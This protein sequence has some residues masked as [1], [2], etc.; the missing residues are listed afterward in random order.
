MADI[1]RKMGMNRS[2]NRRLSPEIS[3]PRRSIT[4]LGPE[5]EEQRALQDKRVPVPGLAEAEQHPFEAVLG[6]YES[7]IVVSFLGEIQEFLSNRGR[8]VFDF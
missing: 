5:F 3:V 6:E 4:L 2:G 7:E 8:K 1:S